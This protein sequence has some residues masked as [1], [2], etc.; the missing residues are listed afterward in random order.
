MLD[1]AGLVMTLWDVDLNV[2][3][4]GPLEQ[5]MVGVCGM[6]FPAPRHTLFCLPWWVPWLQDSLFPHTHN[7]LLFF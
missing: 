1:L 7:T 2:V 3:P 4:A 5:T 6:G